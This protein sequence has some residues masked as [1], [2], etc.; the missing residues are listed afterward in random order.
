MR[1]QAMGMNG[2][3]CFCSVQTLPFVDGQGLHEYNTVR[4]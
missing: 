2:W 1:M 4:N 3:E